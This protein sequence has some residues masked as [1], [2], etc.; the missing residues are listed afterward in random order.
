MVVLDGFRYDYFERHK[1][2]TPFLHSKLDNSIT[3]KMKAG[4]P[5]VTM[6]Q[7]KSIL[8]GNKATYTDLLWN[9]GTDGIKIKQDNFI[10]QLKN[11]H[12]KIHFYGDDTWIK[13]FPHPFFDDYDG[14]HSFYVHDHTEVDN[15]VTRHVNDNLNDNQP[16]VLILHYLGIDHIGHSEKPDTQLGIETLNYK[17]SEMDGIIQKIYDNTDA[18]KTLFLIT[19][20]HGMDS[21]GIHGGS[22]YT[23][24]YTFSMV[25]FPEKFNGAKFGILNSEELEKINLVDLSATISPLLD[26]PLPDRSIGKTLTVDAEILK[27]A[28]FRLACKLDLSSSEVNQLKNKIEIAN[29]EKLVDVQE[30]LAKE[31][32][33]RNKTSIDFNF[34]AIGD[35]PA[36]PRKGQKRDVKEDAR[37]GRKRGRKKRRKKGPVFNIDLI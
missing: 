29:L 15:N 26:L 9:F 25:L 32:D 27:N 7:I 5:T 17:F 23:E 3:F 18:E 30:S 13:L 24:L 36:N 34:I 11:K 2:Y 22:D 35:G 37:K 28:I 10:Q 31:L 16:D 1:N 8:T 12:K 33:A 4:M 19:G 14:T 21:N 20:D 6:P